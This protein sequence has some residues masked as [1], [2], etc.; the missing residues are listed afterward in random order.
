MTGL[1]NTWRRSIGWRWFGAWLDRNGPFF[2]LALTLGPL[3]LWW[4]WHSLGRSRESVVRESVGANVSVWLGRFGIG[5]AGKV[6]ADWWDE[7]KH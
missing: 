5:M 7:F 4:N 2:T 3:H 6:V 1:A